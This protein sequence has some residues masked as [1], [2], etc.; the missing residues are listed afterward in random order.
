MA[1]ILAVD[2]EPLVRRAVARVMGRLGHVVAEA[3]DVSTA[4]RMAQERAYDIAFVDYDMQ[5]GPDGLAVLGKLRELSPRCV[6]ILMTGRTDFPVVIQAINQ[7]EVLR[8]L[9]KPFNAEQLEDVL[10]D[11][12]AAARRMAAIA[13]DERDVK[14]AVRL[15]QELVDGAHVALAVQPIVASSDPART[16]AVECLLRSDH[17]VLTSPASILRAVERSGRIFEMGGLVNQLAARWAAALPADILVFVNVHPVQLDDPEVVARLAPL[18]PFAER[19]VL[20]IT[21]RASIRDISRWEQ[22][23][24]R[25][26]AL[27]FRFALDDLGSGYG[28]LALLADLRPAF[29]KVDTS[30]VRDVHLN[31]NKQRLVDVLVTFANA[32][33]ARLV[34]EGVETEHEAACL[35]RC[36]AHLL[37][38]FHFG[39]PTRVWPGS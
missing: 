5:G 29:I 23:I 36:G 6:R 32:T 4:P 34:A 39:R 33:G 18:V 7:G 28:G 38:G 35:T 8:V 12:V 15:F 2:D 25:I 37:Q 20:E 24:A 9:P 30:I 14:S 19:V 3:G 21:E 22:T 31:P 11:G 16:L 13:D 17:P 27:G 26:E 1:R 10:R